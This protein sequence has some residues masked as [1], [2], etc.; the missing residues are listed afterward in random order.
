MEE[1]YVKRFYGP[2]RPRRDADFFHSYFITIIL[3][4]YICGAR[5]IWLWL[6]SPFQGQI[7]AMETDDNICYMPSYLFHTV[8]IFYCSC[9]IRLLRREDVES[10]VFRLKLV[11]EE[12]NLGR[13]FS[14]STVYQ[15]SS[16]T[17]SSPTLC[18]PTDGSTPGL[19]VHHQLLE[20][21]QTQVPRVGDAIKPSHP[22][23]SPSL[24]AFIL[25]QHQGQ[26]Q[27]VSSSHQVAKVMELQL[28]NQS[29]QWIVKTDFL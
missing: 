24:P 23:S 17:R 20:L 1:S 21:A 5:E 18:D 27:W 15:F 26:F 7:Y 14:A 11:R 6:C 16:V 10:S 22:M 13:V 28:Q 29:F 25:L 4:I 9:Y 3:H 2:A 8:C 19:P 12:N